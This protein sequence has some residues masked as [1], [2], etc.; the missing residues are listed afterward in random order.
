[1]GVRTLVPSRTEASQIVDT[2]N[3]PHMSVSAVGTVATEASVVPGTVS[4]LGLG[5]DVE[6]GTFLVV[7]GIES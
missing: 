3:S 6:E 4:H 5:V 1:M 2:E 7:A